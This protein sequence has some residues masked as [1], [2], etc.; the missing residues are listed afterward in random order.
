MPFQS[1]AQNRWAH[2]PEGTKALG[3]PEKVKE[4]E[5]ATDYKHLPARKGYAKGGTVKKAAGLQPH[6][7]PHRPS[8]GGVNDGHGIFAEGGPVRNSSNDRFYKT[9]TRDE[10]G[11]F[12]GTT[13]RFTGGRKPAGF[14][15]EARTDEDWTKPKG[16]GLTDADDYGDCKTLDPVLPHAKAGGRSY[17]KD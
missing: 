8:E 16:V 2:T 6:E 3:G 7:A 9:D 4:W 13:D 1:D 15:E 14:P 17:A 11:R 5:R 12:L 10:F